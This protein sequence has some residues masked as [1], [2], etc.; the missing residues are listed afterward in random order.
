MSRSKP[1][2]EGFVTEDQTDVLQPESDNEAV[3]QEWLPAALRPSGGPIWYV[4]V[5]TGDPG[6]GPEPFHSGLVHCELA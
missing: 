5:E 3:D 2:V 1:G 4:R 6:P